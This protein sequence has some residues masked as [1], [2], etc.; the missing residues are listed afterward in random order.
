MITMNNGRRVY[1]K[2]DH[3]IMKKSLIILVF[4]TFF[5]HSDVI[6]ILLSEQEVQGDKNPTSSASSCDCHS[7]VDLDLLLHRQPLNE[8]D[9]NEETCSQSPLTEPIDDPIISNTDKF[10]EYLTTETLAENEELSSDKNSRASLFKLDKSTSIHSLPSIPSNTFDNF[11][12]IEKPF[13]R[14]PTLGKHE[15]WIA[16]AMNSYQHPFHDHSCLSPRKCH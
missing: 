12:I 14:N 1:V 15:H 11:F 2:D 16:N 5:I 8:I 13:S 4:D 3:V 10:N 7:D 6:A 9:L